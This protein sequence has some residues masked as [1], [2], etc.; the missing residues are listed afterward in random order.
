[1]PDEQRDVG[2]FGQ[3]YLDFYAPELHDGVNDEESELVARLTQLAPGERVL[4]LPCGHGRIAERLAAWGADVVGVDN[5]P[6]G[7]SPASGELAERLMVP[8]RRWPKG[9]AE[10][11]LDGVGAAAAP[12]PAPAVIPATTL[13]PDPGVNLRPP[14]LPATS[15]LP[16]LPPIWWRAMPLGLLSRGDACM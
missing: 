8:S 6:I 12:A 4:D 10:E 9:V 3:D 16:R 1:M 13:D 14:F 5:G 11:R 15:M 7:V 2:V